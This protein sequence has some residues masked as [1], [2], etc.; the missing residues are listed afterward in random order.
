[1]TAPEDLPVILKAIRCYDRVTDACLNTMKSKAL[2]VGGWSTTT[3]ALDISYSPEIKILGF[4]FMSTV[5]L[6]IKKSWANIPGNVHAQ[7]REAYGRNLGLPQRIL[8]VHSYCL[9]KIWQTAQVF[10]APSVR[11]RELVSA[12]AWYIWQG[13]TFRVPISILQRRKEHGGWELIDIA[14]KCRA[15]LISRMWTQ[16][17]MEISAKAIWFQRWWCQTRRGWRSRKLLF[18]Y[19]GSPTIVSEW[20]PDCNMSRGVFHT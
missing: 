16:G 14:A 2:A 6:S 19:N 5:E 20:V 12:T 11:T 1:V 15:L 9:A 17:K 13:A 8:Y 18:V 3:N 7:E 4:S 10:P